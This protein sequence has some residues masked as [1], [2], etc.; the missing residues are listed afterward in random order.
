MLPSKKHRLFRGKAASLK[1][2]GSLL[3]ALLVREQLAARAMHALVRLRQRDVVLPHH[4]HAPLPRLVDDELHALRPAEDLY[5]RSF[6]QGH[7]HRQ[8]AAHGDGAA[9]ASGPA[10]AVLAWEVFARAAL[11]QCLGVM[12]QALRHHTKLHSIVPC[13]HQSIG[14]RSSSSK[15]LGRGTTL[16]HACALKGH[17]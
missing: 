16:G 2:I 1:C 8:V 6:H 3:A 15:A 7:A 14:S 5:V 13:E 9:E 17:E 11:V 10:A 12:A 4:L